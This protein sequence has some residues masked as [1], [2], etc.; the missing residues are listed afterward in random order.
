MKRREVMAGL[1]ALAATP[2]AAFAAP[3]RVGLIVW[4]GSVMMLEGK[5]GGDFVAAMRELG[6][7]HGRDVLYEA[8]YWKKQEDAPN[9]VAE[10]LRWK[11]DVIVAAGPPSILAAKAG[12]QRVPI[13]MMYSAEPVAMGIVSSLARP[14]G[15]ITGLTYDHGFETMAKAVEL[16]R[17]VMPRLRR[18]AIVWDGTDAAHPIYASHF[19][20]VATQFKLTP[21]SVGLKSVADIEPGFARIRAERAEGLVLLPS[22][23][24]TLPNRH[25]ILGFV[26]RDRL[27]TIVNIVDGRDYPG[28]ILQYGPN[29]SSMPRRAAS[30]VD[31]VLKGARPADIPVEQPDK[32]DLVVH[33]PAARKLGL[34][35]PQSILLRADRVVE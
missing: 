5:A 8:R 2:R 11:A 19:A 7:L 16:L 24:I 35:V 15:N 23:Q 31:R 32:Y 28:A 14:G 21:I 13:V 26:A 6:Y 20:K 1:I 9:M 25:A 27:P 33:L 18:V 17:D 22:A 10:L 29:Y 30:F 34:K 12:T 4:D 3:R